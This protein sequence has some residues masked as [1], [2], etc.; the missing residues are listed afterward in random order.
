MAHLPEET[1]YYYKPSKNLRTFSLSLIALGLALIAMQVVFPWHHGEGEHHG[2]PR[3]FLSLHLGLLIALPLALGGVY[4]VAL[5]H[6]AGSAWNV[7]VRRIAENYIWF[8]PFVFLLMLVIL[9][10]GIGDV[11]HH[12]VHA[13][14]DDELINGKRGW[15]NTGFFISRNLLWVVVW[16]IFGFIFYRISRK[17][18]EDGNAAHTVRMSKLGAGFLVVFALTYSM[19]AWDLGMSIE[20]HWFSTIWAVYSFAGLA[21]TTFSSL[22]I[23]VWYLKRNGYYGDALNENHIHDLGKYM[24]GHTIF[25]GYIGISQFLLIWYGNIPEETFFYHNR[26]Y[27]ETMAYNPWAYVSLMLVV[28]RFFLPFLLIIRRDTKRNLNYLASIAVLI[29]CGQILDLYWLAYP[30][31]AHGDFVMFSWREVGPIALVLGAFI[32]IISS[33]LSRG[34]LIPV[35]DPRLEDCLNWHQ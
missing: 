34:S 23:W 32:F 7:I 16:F 13:Q 12:W 15:L 20:P 4:F 22:V 1:K 18:D 33:A 6:L 2:N 30:T 31:L 10:F 9:V 19:T 35:K 24:W 14:P 28:V 26:L 25:W 11:F 5:N 3:L 17:Q 27:T 29:I 8:L 21:L